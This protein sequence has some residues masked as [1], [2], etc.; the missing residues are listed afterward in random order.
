MYNSIYVR[1]LKWSN[2][3]RQKVEWWLLAAGGRGNEQ[4]LFNVYRLSVLQDEKALEIDS[5]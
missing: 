1:Y 4:L 3:W 2:S 5:G